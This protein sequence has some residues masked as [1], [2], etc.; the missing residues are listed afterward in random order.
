MSRIASKLDLPREKAVEAYT[1]KTSFEQR[2]DA[3]MRKTNSRQEQQQAVSA[4]AAQA[5]AELT[6][7]LG[8][9]GAAAY[10]DYGNLFR[11]L[12][13]SGPGPTPVRPN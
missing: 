8:E 12:R 10:K 7:V 2:A 5:E 13:P 9:K 3:V 11:R 6:R 4:L 1:I